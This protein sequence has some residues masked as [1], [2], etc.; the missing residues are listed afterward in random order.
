[1]DVRLDRLVRAYDIRTA[2]GGTCLDRLDA[3]L[4]LRDCD[5]L[6]VEVE[7]LNLEFPANPRLLMTSAVLAW[8]G[9]DPIRA[10]QYLDALLA[11]QPRSPD[12]AVLRARIAMQEGNLTFA[13]RLLSQQALLVPD[14]AE[15]RETLAAVRFLQRRY[16]EATRQLDAAAR[17]GAPAWRISYHRGLLA[18]AEQRPDE[19]VAYYEAS[20]AENPAFRPAQARL[21]GLGGR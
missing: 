15:V 21:E 3:N 4:P 14:H 16:D 8:N 7:R 1:V 10:Q 2:E 9:G 19:A 6:R 13:D 12:A 17:L 11:L 18:E 5:R 20:V